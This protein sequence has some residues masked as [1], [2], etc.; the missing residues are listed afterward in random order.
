MI[1]Y[2]KY[3]YIF[4]PRPQHALP[5]SSLNSYDNGQYLAQPKL[6][7]DCMLIFTN[8]IEYIVKDR[9]NK[10]FKKSIAML[11]KLKTLHRESTPGANKWM[12]LVGEYMIKSKKNTLGKVW[13]EKFAIHDIIAFDGVQLVGKTNDERQA[14]LDKLYGI[15][16]TPLGDSY[17]DKFL[18]AT[19]LEDIYRMKNFY[20]NFKELY[21][22]MVKTDMYEGLVL[23]KKSGKLENGT[24]EKNNTNTQFK[25]RKE[26]KNYLQ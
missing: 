18:Y 1:A 21:D 20:G 4:P 8:G 3:R 7:G 11:P 16:E 22:E 2:D 19:D 24:S 14:L 6:N 5:S 13:N 12:A 25:F 17:I 23:K 15:S 10:D 26:T 9:H